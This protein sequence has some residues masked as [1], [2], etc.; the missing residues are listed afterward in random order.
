[1]Q[2]AHQI[3]QFEFGIVGAVAGVNNSLNLAHPVQ[4]AASEALDKGQETFRIL[5]F[6]RGCWVLLVIAVFTSKLV[7]LAETEAVTR[8]GLL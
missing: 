8:F 6:Q 5:C 3:I 2:A 4:L 7:E 1:M